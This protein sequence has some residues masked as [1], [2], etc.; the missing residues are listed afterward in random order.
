[1][2]A[3]TWYIKHPICRSVCFSHQFVDLATGWT[4]WGNCWWQAFCKKINKSTHWLDNNT[5]ELQLS[6][7]FT[8]GVEH[9]KLLLANKMAAILPTNRSMVLKV[10]HSKCWWSLCCCTS[11]GC[12][13]RQPIS[14][15][16]RQSYVWER[17]QP[18]VQWR[19]L[20]GQVQ[21]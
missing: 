15:Q 21:R 19:Y 17:T 2:W 9:D 3:V 20:E 7:C 11:S 6:S 14:E 18:D 13:F 4:G 16:L 5:V 10:C 8:L 12:W 1:M